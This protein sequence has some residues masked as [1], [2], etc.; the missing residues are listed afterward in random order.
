MQFILKRMVTTPFSYITVIRRCK[1]LHQDQVESISLP[2][3]F[4]LVTFFF[5]C[6]AFFLRGAPTVYRIS[7][8]MA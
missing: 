3:G 7:Q 5:V 2:S 1:S 8:A 6:F 4:V